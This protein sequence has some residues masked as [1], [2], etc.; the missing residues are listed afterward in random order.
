MLSSRWG[1]FGGLLSLGTMERLPREFRLSTEQLFRFNDKRSQRH[2][3]E[4]CEIVHRAHC[5]TLCTSF[6]VPHV[7]QAVT[8]SHS[9]VHL[10][11]PFFLPTSQKNLTKSLL[12]S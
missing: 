7:A 3:K 1:G 10:G 12:K 11:K 6:D 2:I 5:R 4:R 8:G 9:K